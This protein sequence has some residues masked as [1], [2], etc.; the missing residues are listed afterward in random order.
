MESSANEI[1]LG[2][3]EI[4]FSKT[5]ESL[6]NDTA[7]GNE[8]RLNICARGFW[9]AG[10]AAFFDVRV[11]NPNATRYARLELLKST[12]LTKKRKRSIIINV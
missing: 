2:I 3:T 12:K 1:Q 10:Q 9:V 8:F 5:G 6:K 7:K 11:F 4:T